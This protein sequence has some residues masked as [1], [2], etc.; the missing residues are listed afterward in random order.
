MRRL[1]QL[2]VFGST[3]STVSFAQTQTLRGTV[4]DYDSKFPLVG[5]NVILYKDTTIAKVVSTDV[6]GNYRMEGVPLGRNKVKFSYVSY[7]ERTIDNV[8]AT[9]GKEVILNV[10]LVE[11]VNEISE[12]VVSA[13]KPGQTRDEMATVSAR[14]FTI[15]ETDRYAGSRGDPARMVSNFAGVSGAD[16]SRNDIVIRG[17]SPSGVLWRMEGIP[18]LNPNHFNIPG[19]SGSPITIL[20]NKFLSNSDFF[21]SAFPAEFGNTVSGIF[22]LYQRNGN[23]EKYEFS[24]QVGFLGTEALAE[25][26]LSKNH[27][28]SFLA[29]YRY[30]TLKLFDLVG[31]DIGTNSVPKYQD[32]FFRVNF[33]LKKNASL[34]F[35]GMGGL[36]D[37]AILV[38]NQE[39]P[40]A[41]LYAQNDRDQHFKSNMGI[42]GVTYSK[43]FSANTYMK[44]TIAAQGN[45]V[46]AHHE[47]VYRHTDSEGNYVVDS[48]LPILD[49]TFKEGRYS[50]TWFLN[51][52]LNSHWLMKL[53][54][55]ADA[56]TYNYIDSSRNLDS[57]SKYYYQYSTRWDSKGVTSLV[58][59]YIQFQ[60]KPD[61]R[62]TF[63]FGAHAQ[64]FALSNSASYFEPRF[65]I[66][67]DLGNNQIIAFGTGLHSQQQNLYLYFY[68]LQDSTNHPLPPHNLDMGFTRSLHFVG[69]YSRLI[70]QHYYL[71]AEAYYQRLFDVPVNDYS[72]SFSLINTGV[73]FSRF[74]PDTL[75]NEGS[76]YNY[77]LE[78]TL[79]R[80]FY[81]QYFF[82]ITGTLFNSKYKGSDDVLRNTDF[83][84]QYI[85]NLLG[86]K[87][88]TVLKKNTIGAGGKMTFEGGHW[89]GP[90]DTLESEQQK[91]VIYDDATRNSLQF[92]PYFRVDLKFYY[93]INGKKISQEIGLD[94]VNVFDTKNILNLT[95]IP[96]EDDPSRSVIQQNYQL[97]R[98]PIFYYRID[99]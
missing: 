36:S 81:K 80:L 26:P 70:A 44:A 99:F 25:G 56:L 6:D 55:N 53:G 66:K 9:S 61:E 30:S 79:Q 40:T 13:Y 52:K 4:T 43:T 71:L 89:Y 67:Y 90:V 84:T 73:G 85:L 33:Q 1:L 8:I 38:S 10:Q 60:Y 11:A 42:V 75:T 32:A 2:I 15:E 31:I 46:Y 76:G 58:Q 98:L 49:Y 97:G 87:E 22:D 21:T 39:Q 37:V 3:F 7:E 47:L 18:I 88:W 24:A 23:D 74:F 48:L 57:T 86:T 20:N 35:F 93:K 95:Y 17:N 72:S 82:M 69:S 96:N 65:G 63:N 83:N 68:R 62:L 51:H 91:E 14:P 78:L 45:Y 19:T 50:A 28:S 34:S 59:P 92:A 5:V 54:F 64:Y 27:K 16:D 94:I 29:T 41:D 77:G 12:V